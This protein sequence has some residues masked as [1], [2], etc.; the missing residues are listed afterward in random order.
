MQD[1]IKLKNFDILLA[2]HSAAIING[3]WDL[4]V[5]LKGGDDE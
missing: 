4:T 3:N 1:I 2:T 5:S